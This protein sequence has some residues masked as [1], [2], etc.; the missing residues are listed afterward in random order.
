[1]RKKPIVHCVHGPSLIVKIT[2]LLQ[3]RCAYGHC[4]AKTSTFDGKGVATFITIT[5]RSTII[6]A[7]LDEAKRYRGATCVAVPGYF[8]VSLLRGSVRVY[9]RIYNQH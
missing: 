6:Y 5:A 8:E 2:R 7:K 9:S 3:S 4:G 1:M